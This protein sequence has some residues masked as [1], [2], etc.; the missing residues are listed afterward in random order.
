MSNYVK[1]LNDELLSKF[2]NLSQKYGL[3][4]KHI[5]DL[6]YEECLKR[7]DDMDI[8]L[9]LNMLRSYTFFSFE[10]RDIF[11]KSIPKLSENVDSFSNDDVLMFLNVAK[12]LSQFPELIQFRD[13][14]LSKM[15][16]NLESQP[17]THLIRCVGE[18][19]RG[20]RSRSGKMF[21]SNVLDKID[22]DDFRLVS[23]TNLVN[24]MHTINFYKM[25]LTYL[26]DILT[27]L[28][29]RMNEIVSN[30]N[31]GL[32]SEIFSVLLET[33]WFSL[34]FMQSAIKHIISE[35][36]VL[37]RVSTY[38]IVRVLQ[39]FYKLRL[40][41][42]ESYQTLLDSIERGFDMLVP[43]FN[44]IS[45]TIL[46]AADANIEHET[47][48]T[49]SLEFFDSRIQH[50][51]LL[52]RD[53]DL[54]T[55]MNKNYI[56]PRNVITSAWSM[57]VMDLHK[58]DGFKTLLELIVHRKFAE[59]DFDMNTILMCLETAEACMVDEVNMELAQEISDLFG[60][61]MRFKEINMEEE[62][63]Y[64]TLRDNKLSF[65]ESQNIHFHKGRSRATK[66]IQITF[67]YFSYFQILC[68]FLI[69][70]ILDNI[71]KKDI[72]LKVSPHYNS[73]YII[74]IC[75]PKEN[76][77]GIVLFSGRELLRN[78]VDSTWS[79]SN[80]GSSKLK[81]KIL[82]K[83]NWNVSRISFTVIQVAQVSCSQ[84]SVLNTG[85]E[86]KDFVK[87]LLTELNISY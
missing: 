83:Q 75:F 2:S 1:L 66:H 36:Q 39:T 68:L 34:P 3:R 31:L 87:K 27:I 54:I 15:N 79:V 23:V 41:H 64:E 55:V 24:V 80:T 70:G 58:R 9:T 84:W 73:P 25:K 69:S 63:E 67:N 82:S 29:M 48:F 77:K 35:P 37:C 14:I 16:E 81:L 65:N 13:L 7:V 61:K 74:D 56:W 60:D 28:S 17:N 38:Q 72:L 44:M 33:G 21:V 6:C 85:M 4:T 19:Y 40:Y 59:Q 43:K 45:E 5:L 76:K 49:R 86:R 32:W 18:L 46:A 62:V 78:H 42:K 8:N 22:E 51:N 30:R 12:T 26:T 10:Y 57:A 71:N 52:E 50:L 20:S 11:L 53:D 47:L